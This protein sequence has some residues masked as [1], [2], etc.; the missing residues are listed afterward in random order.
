MSYSGRLELT[1]TNKNKT[2]LALDDGTYQWVDPSDHR[3]AEVRL[4]TDAATV[5]AT[6]P[7]RKRA[8]DNLL[9][10][11]DALHALQSLNRIPEFAS[12]YVGKVRLCYIDPPFNTG[13]A[14]SQYDDNLEHSVW[15]TM[16]RDRLMQIKPLLAPDGS[17][18]VHLDD[19]EVHRCRSV[20]D[21][22]FGEGAFI[23]TVIWQKKY[24]RENRP[25]MGTVHDYI[26][27]FAPAGQAWKEFRNRLARTSAKEYSN[28]TNDPR[29]PWRIVPM[30]APGFRPNQMYEIEGPDG[31]IH[32]P[33]KGRCWSMIRPRY[34]E[35]LA[36]GRISFGPDGSSQPGIIRFLSEDEGLVPWTW[37]PHEEVG[38]TDEAK[39]EMLAL[40]PDVEPFDTPKPERLMQRIIHI[41]T[42]PGDI[43]LDCFAGSGTTAAVAHKMGRRWVTCEREAKT[44]S[45]FTLPRLTKVVNNEDPGGITSIEVP[46]GEGLPGGVKP[47]DGRDAAKTLGAFLK[48]E[49]LDGFDEKTV[50][51][52]IKALRDADRTRT[53]TLWSGGGGFRVLDVGP[54]MFEEV[55]GRVYLA[56][57]AV[58]GKLAEAVAAQYGYA[59]EPDGPFCGTKGQMR[60][61]VI[62]GLVNDAVI[63]LLVDA[64][65]EGQRVVVCATAVDPDARAVLRELRPGSTLK[66]VPASLLSE[67]QAARRDRLRMV[68]V[69]DRADNPEFV[70]EGERV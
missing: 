58:N 61:A 39:K 57:W 47:G 34:E 23:A 67:Y 48:D 28:P 10:R 6:N 1:W 3:V 40:F 8:G 24:S 59:Y 56:G 51:A 18:W 2:L 27:V 29:G 49:M 33:P 69:L 19:A 64:L 22:V 35:A 38:H 12:E 42:D 60:L 70:A 45:T 41:A 30:T 7:D 43:V 31:R 32:L 25:A 52:I 5:G 13:Q 44:V 36:A 37:W 26:M 46:T 63:R 66:K 53:E 20:M 11:G 16:L 9:I 65:P 50:R 68:S 4:L 62:D 14:F 15:L 54:S 55:D 17:V 21:E